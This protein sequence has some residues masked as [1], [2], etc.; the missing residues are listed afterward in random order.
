MVTYGV[1]YSTVLVRSDCSAIY[2]TVALRFFGGP[3]QM[4]GNGYSTVR[5]LVRLLVA[6]A[7][8]NTKVFFR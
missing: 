7:S 8:L 3:R 6:K 2:G 5:V 4:D 1:A